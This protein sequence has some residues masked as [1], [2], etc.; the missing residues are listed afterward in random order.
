MSAHDSPQAAETET[1]AGGLP[2]NVRLLGWASLLND[3]ASEAVYPLLPQF[4]LELGGGRTAL[5]FLEGLADTVA[6]LLKL[7]TGSW[8]DRLGRRKVFLVVGYA[9]AGLSRPCLGFATRVAHVVAVRLLD[10]IGKGLRTAPRDAMI[11]ESTAESQ[12]GFAFG[13]HRAMDH[14]GAAVGPLL[15][16]AFLWWMPSGLR[17]LMLLTVI[18][19]LIVLA[20]QIWGLREAASHVQIGGAA[21]GD[22]PRGPFR[23]YLIS[24]LVFTFANSSDAFLL[25]L[26]RELGVT[27]AWL[28]VL[29]SLQ[30]VAKSVGNR[31][32]G[33]L[34]DRR[35]PRRLI[36]AGWTYYAAVYLGFGFAT[37]AWHAWGLFLAYAA[38]FALTEPAEKKL[39]ARFAATGKSGAAFGWFHTVLGVSNLPSSLLFGWLYETYGPAAAFA[40]GALAALL[41]AGL[42]TRVREAPTG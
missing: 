4:L 29:W 1:N 38:F 37:Q 13:Y 34:A 12:R 33:R 10:R 26:A 3:V 35:S 18:P 21:S 6:S 23:L 2:R 25:V 8:S 5:G 16:A 40:W 22:I 31:F 41:A 30:Q 19:G 9:L 39:V 42:L 11:T 17:T 32:G 36:L 14:L 7:W 28:P 20:L 27:M 15:G 24:L